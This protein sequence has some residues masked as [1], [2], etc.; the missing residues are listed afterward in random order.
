MQW[1]ERGLPRLENKVP[2]NSATSH[3]SMMLLCPLAEGGDLSRSTSLSGTPTPTPC[4]LLLLTFSPTSVRPER[5]SSGS[6]KL[7]PG[8]V[9]EGGAADGVGWEK[10]QVG[11]AAGGSCWAGL[12]VRGCR[13][14]YLRGG[15]SLKSAISL[16]HLTETCSPASWGIEGPTVGGMS[17][18]GLWPW[19]LALLTLPGKRV[20]SPSSPSL[21]WLQ[22]TQCGIGQRVWLGPAGMPTDLPDSENQLLGIFL[23]VSTWGPQEG[24]LLKTLRAEG[25]Q[26]RPCR[27]SPQAQPD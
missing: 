1:W 19:V 22:P 16:L 15:S 6:R 21:F 26:E 11:E 10:L 17:M 12:Q 9:R 27:C 20:A 2:P 23:E 7:G 8:L 5:V 13:S 25:Q 18:G 3:L 4:A 14:C 24:D